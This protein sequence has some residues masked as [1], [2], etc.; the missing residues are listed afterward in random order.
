MKAVLLDP[1]TGRPEPDRR[2]LQENLER[3]W[4]IR[5]FDG[6]APDL[7]VLP[8]SIL[9]NLE[10]AGMIPAWQQPRGGLQSWRETLYATIA[11]GT[12]VTAA[13]ET[14][15]VPDFTF[16]AN[17]LYPGR[18]LKYTLWGK[19]S[20]VITTPG[21]ITQRLRWGGVG[22]TSLA[23]S[24]AYAPDPTAAST[25]LTFYTE[26]FLVCRAT[27]T[28]AASLAFGRTW[29]PDIDDATVT[30]IKGNLDMHTIPASAPA[31]TNI[32]TTTANA[33]SPTWTQSVATGSMTCM[34]ATIE[35]LT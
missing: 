8:D 3:G 18:V 17:Y 14:I 22:G 28:S 7:S 27:G 35:S 19:Y 6:D 30:T 11:D 16:P 12:A 24:G 34:F 21:T 4:S 33:L 10:R 31:T 15:M 9:E 25:D 1:R 26:Y 2:Q 23:A 29:L 5:G 32:N 20:T 13:A